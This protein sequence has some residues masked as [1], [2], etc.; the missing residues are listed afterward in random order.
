MV[1]VRSQTKD[2]ANKVDLKAAKEFLELIGE[3]PYT[4]QAFD[5]T[6][7]EHKDRRLARIL[8]GTLD[9]HADTLCS[10]NRRGAGVFVAL[11]K[12]D[13]K[14]RRAENIVAVRANCLDL[15]GNPLEA[16][17]QCRLR[18]HIVVESSPGRFHVYWLVTDEYPKEFEDIQRAI[19]KRFDGDPAVAILTHC[20]RLPGFFHNKATP[21]RTRIKTWNVHD[22]YS[23]DEILAE[24]PAEKRPHKAPGSHL[25]L[26]ADNPMECARQFLLALFRDATGALWLHY[27]RGSF[28]HWRHTH[29]KERDDDYVRSGLYTFLHKALA[30]T[31]DG[32]QPFKPNTDK[33]NKILDALR[34]GCYQ[35]AEQEAPM[36]MDGSDHEPPERLIACRNGLL[37][38]KTFEVVLHSPH[39]FNLNALSFDYAA[40]ASAPQRWHQFLNELWPDDKAAHATLQEIFGLLLTTDTS[41][42]K[43]FML[44]GPMRSGKGTIGYVLTM[45]LGRNNVANPTMAG[46]ATQFG[47]WPL[48]DKPLAI[49]PDGRL[50]FGKEGR[51]VVEHLLSISGEDR[52]TIDR[53]YKDYWTGK[54][55][56]RFLMLTNELPRFVDASGALASRFVILTITQSFLGKEDLDLKDKLGAELPGILNWAIDGL[57][58]LRKRGRFEVPQSSHDAIQQMADLSSPVAAF[59]REKCQFGSK[60]LSI[61]KAR[62]YEAWKSHCEAQGENAGSAA[63]FGRNLMAAFPTVRSGH[64]GSRKLYYGIEL[65]DDSADERDDESYSRRHGR[66]SGSRRRPRYEDE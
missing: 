49:V 47:L 60:K 5:D 15:D 45:L 57:L 64:S 31:K 7:A 8:H 30:D 46:L 19:A 14:G 42:Q 36:W 18:P 62:L 43:I 63:V 44:V 55:A 27:Y 61:E 48:I 41:Y 52:L 21:F 59:V 29:Y 3:G 66:D 6:T 10:L 23:S 34:S 12:T 51:Q 22:A 25:I 11:N 54:L 50:P 38:L 37:D 17:W 13:G 33:V 9:E 32:V 1:V 20:A 58:R 53:K 56:C 2:D 26:P 28:Y 16:V 65:K 4:F 35:D 40:H 24:F 39:F